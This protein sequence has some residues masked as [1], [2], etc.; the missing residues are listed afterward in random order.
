MPA[1]YN[2]CQSRSGSAS[3]SKESND[4]LEKI[5]K[6]MSVEYLVEVTGISDP[7]EVD[8]I[9]VGNAPGIPSL[10]NS[11][12]VDPEN[13]NIFPYFSAKSKTVERMDENGFW[14]TVTVEYDDE[15]GEEQNQTPPNDPEDIPATLTWTSSEKVQT[16]W[17]TTDGNKCLLPTRTYYS[18]PTTRKVPVLTATLTQFENT[19]NDSLMY[20]RLYHC[21][22]DSWTPGTKNWGAYQAMITDIKYE[23]A[24]VPV[25][26]GITIPS[27]KV[28]YTI[29]CVK[30][31][32]KNLK[33]DGNPEDK[34]VGHEQ[35][36]IRADSRF[37][38]GGGNGNVKVA[39]AGKHMGLSSIYL[40]ADG[41]PFPLDK[42]GGIPPHDFLKTQPVTGFNVFLR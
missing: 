16:A 4:A 38:D 6:T 33:E 24:R 2:V 31:T 42:Q 28:T 22:S 18:V 19:F 9:M 26:G 40:K 32:V 20:G 10:A 29:E 15:T 3:F 14:F 27:N 5:K 34:T 25:V 13:G 1:S 39:L 8:P 11:I 17:S 23:S 21:N 35:V 30:Y 37:L 7:S 41:T 12:Y 36:R